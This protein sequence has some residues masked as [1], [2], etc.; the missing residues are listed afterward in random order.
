MYYC[1][2]YGMLTISVVALVQSVADTKLRGVLGF[3][4][5][6]DDDDNNNNRYL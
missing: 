2:F 1:V 3:P 6:K 5:S 4:L